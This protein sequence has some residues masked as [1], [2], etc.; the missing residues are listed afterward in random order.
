MIGFNGAAALQQRRGSTAH[1][2]Q[3]RQAGELQ[4]GRCS[5]AA[6]GHRCGPGS[7]HR[8][9]DASTGPL[10]FS[11]G[12]AMPLS[13]GTPQLILLQRGRCSSAAE[14]PDTTSSRSRGCSRFNGAA[15]L[16]Q[17]RARATPGRGV[18]GRGAS[19]GP[20]LFSSGG[21]ADLNGAS[22]VMAP[23][24]R[25]RCS[26][27]AEGPGAESPW[28]RRSSCFNGAA[29]LQQRRGTISRRHRRR[30]PLLQRGRCSSAA[31][32]SWLCM[33]RA[34]NTRSLQRGRCSSAAEGVE[35]N[36]INRQL[37][38]LQRGRCSSAAEG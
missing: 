27:A 15:A 12:G 23:L 20:L 11:S 28:P 13:R 1:V 4:R 3:P 37:D 31:E 35:G 16:Q 26:S 6:E 34:L 8:G 21:I 24:Q 17:R 2:P 10:L 32:G 30:D 22:L 36:F 5:S 9:A 14:G 7:H 18:A 29:A 38:A 25:G 19:T 33:R